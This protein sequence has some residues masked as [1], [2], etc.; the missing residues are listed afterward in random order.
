MGKLAFPLDAELTGPDRVVLDILKR[1]Y[2]LHENSPNG[3]ALDA[4]E[5]SDDSDLLDQ[6]Q[7]AIAYLK[8]LNDPKSDS[9][10]IS[11]FSSIDEPDIKNPFL[12]QWIIDPYI[13]WTKHVVRVETDVIMVTHLLL[14]FCT[15]IPSAAYLYINFHWWHAVLHCVMQG[16][17]MGAYT[18][19]KHQHIHMRGVLSKK[20]GLVDRIFPYIL[21][22]MMGHTW[23]SYYYHHVKHHHVEGNG[24]ND[25]SSTIRYQRDSVWD[26]MQY[27]GRFYFLIWF[28]LPLYF[29]R[30]RKPSLAFQAGG[31]E[32]SNYVFL[33]LMYNYVNT[34]A[35]AFVF[36]IPLAF[37]RLAL[38]TGNWGQHAF[39][40]E[41]EPDSDFR[42]SIT[43]IDTPSNR[44]CYNDGYHTSHHLNPLRHWR[45]HPVAFLSQKKQYSD[46]QAIV[47]Y[48]IDYFFLTINLLRKNYEHI[49][50]CLVPMGDQ[51]KLTLDEKGEPRL[52]LFS[53]DSRI[54]YFT[55]TLS[56]SVQAYS[57]S[58]HKLL[59]S[60]LSHLSPPNTI[61]TSANGTVLLSASPNPPTIYLQDLRWGGSAPVRFCPADA[62]GPASCAAFHSGTRS[63]QRPYTSFVTGFQDGMLT[64]YRLFLPSPRKCFGESY[65][66]E[67]HAFQ[68]QPVRM[69]VIKKLHKA[70]MGGITAAEFIPGYKSR[71][72]SVGYDGK[73]RLVD[74]EGGVLEIPVITVQWVGDMSATSHFSGHSFSFS[75]EAHS[76][77]SVAID[78]PSECSDDENGTVKK[79]SLPLG[80]DAVQRLPPFRPPLDL[81][82]VNGEKHKPGMPQPQRSAIPSRSPLRKNRSCEKQKRPLLVRPRISTETFR[83]PPKLHH[84]HASSAATPPISVDIP[85]RESRRWSQMYQAPL[86]SPGFRVQ[87]CSSPH[88]S[89]SS[90]DDSEISEQKW[91]TPPSTRRALSQAL[92]RQS[93]SS[94]PLAPSKTPKLHS[95][96]SCEAS[97]PLSSTLDSRCPGLS[98]RKSKSKQVQ[99][100][101]GS[102]KN[103]ALAS[104][105]VTRRRVTMADPESA[106]STNTTGSSNNSPDLRPAQSTSKSHQQLRLHEALGRPVNKSVQAQQHV[107]AATSEPSSSLD[108]LYAPP[109]PVKDKIT[110]MRHRESPNTKHLAS[111][112][113]AR[114]TQSRLRTPNGPDVAEDSPSSAYSRSISGIV[115]DTDRTDSKMDDAR[116]SA[117]TATSSVRQQQ[118]SFHASHTPLS[119][120]SPSNLRSRRLSSVF[121]RPPHGGDG[122]CLEAGHRHGRHI[123]IE[124]SSPSMEDMASL[125]QDYLAL[126][127]EVAALREEYRVLKDALLKPRV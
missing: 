1:E 21:D 79:I 116:Q 94:T 11:V 50:K 22:P 84:I 57:I 20:Y 31:C 102:A 91:F 9:F 69:G 32:I 67:T 105:E 35:T 73:C 107:T 63:A 76:L 112:L 3:S 77:R 18:L 108:S 93:H 4:A 8:K 41:V 100:N 80:P 86:V 110:L 26:F 99:E 51:M 61:A 97:S 127:Q 46:E 95:S 62:C 2:E 124:K 118:S 39:V 52:L 92:V 82:S 43:L 59:P 120:R 60:L 64:M 121:H 29:L 40:D 72:V 70:A 12:R 33:Y 55:T 13:Q 47:F 101:E 75:P 119:A 83:F 5:D 24:P 36:L 88:V 87:L 23:N 16:Y 68:L 7:Q 104:V 48:N 45:E 85:V 123:A 89:F 78:G 28:D 126:K 49:A 56:N 25:L 111:T 14:Y 53:A 66:H 90:S 115:R 96:R 38:M 65:A 54:L 58:T 74:F 122:A 109:P 17:Y 106:L 114:T 6:E 81:F 98:P 15:S 10:E 44:Y 34:R 30:T 42:S 71:V 113:V 117:S 125:R 27:V 19:L 103:D 37:M